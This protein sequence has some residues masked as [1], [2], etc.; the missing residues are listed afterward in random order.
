MTPN[1]IMRRQIEQAV[2][3]MRPVLDLPAGGLQ[4]CT[5]AVARYARVSSTPTSAVYITW[6]PR[7]GCRYVGSGC[8]L[9]DVTA[10]RA[11]VREHLRRRERRARWYA[12][13]ILPVTPKT[14]LE[15]I[16]RCE[17]W[18]AFV[19]RPAEGSAHPLIDMEAP[20]TAA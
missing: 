9:E 10:V 6:D 13:T 15:V 16:R 7:G 14:S 5:M 3:L 20:I 17:G 12:V 1:A 18:V 11:R 2:G 19:L 4:A 8:R